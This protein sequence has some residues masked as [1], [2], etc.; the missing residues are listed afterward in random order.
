MDHL[1]LQFAVVSLEI[2]EVA[3]DAIARVHLH[4]KAPRLRGALDHEDEVGVR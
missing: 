1:G 3:G 4:R 2:T